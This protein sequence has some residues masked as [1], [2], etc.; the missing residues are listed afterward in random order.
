MT[1]TP[2]P[3]K[4]ADVLYGCPLSHSFFANECKFRL[5]DRVIF[6]PKIQISVTF[7]VRLM[8]VFLAKIT[9][10]SN[11]LI[12][13]R[14]YDTIASPKVILTKSCGYQENYYQVHIKSHA[15][16]NFWQKNY[17]I[18]KAKFAFICKEK[19][20]HFSNRL[21]FVCVYNTTRNPASRASKRAR[22]VAMYIAVA[23]RPR[24]LLVSFLPEVVAQI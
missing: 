2:H 12:F 5:E 24:V 22:L 19:I 3:L 6:L 4:I 14:V 13:V 7:D 8:I 10:F 1:H 23:I 18:F 16:L 11:R 21:I 17:T 15:N 9:H 20:T